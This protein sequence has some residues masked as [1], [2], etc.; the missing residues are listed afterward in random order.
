MSPVPTKTKRADTAACAT[1]KGNAGVLAVHSC[2]KGVESKDGWADQKSGNIDIMV[3]SG[4]GC[5]YQVGFASD[6]I[7]VIGSIGPSYGDYSCQLENGTPIWHSAKADKEVTNAVLYSMFIRNAGGAKLGI[8][9]FAIPPYGGPV[10]TPTFLWNVSTANVNGTGGEAKPDPI[11]VN[12]PYNSYTYSGDQTLS[13]S[14]PAAASTMTSLTV[15]AQSSAKNS[16]GTGT[17]GTVS[18][19]STSLGNSTSTPNATSAVST[20]LS[21]I[22]TTPSSTGT[23]SSSSSTITGVSKDLSLPFQITSTQLWIGGG[24]LLLIIVIAVGAMAFCCASKG[25]NQNVNMHSLGKPGR[26]RRG[27]HGPRPRQIEKQGYRYST[28]LSESSDMSTNSEEDDDTEVD[29]RPLKADFNTNI[30]LLFL[31]SAVEQLSSEEAGVRR[32]GMWIL[33]LVRSP[34][35]SSASSQCGAGGI[36]AIHNCPTGIIE[37]SQED[38]T[39]SKVGDGSV[40]A[41]ITSGAECMFRATFYSN[42]I[43][44]IGM[45]GPEYGDY[46]CHFEDQPPTW[47]SAKAEVQASNAVL[48]Q[49]EGMNCTS[50]FVSLSPGSGFLQHLGQA[51]LTVSLP[52][53]HAIAIR[54]LGG[55]KLGVTGFSVEMYDQ[56]IDRLWY[57]FN[58][59]TS[60]KP[61][62]GNKSN[63]NPAQM[64]LDPI[65]A[66]LPFDQYTYTGRQTETIPAPPEASTFTP[67]FATSAP[68]ATN[69]AQTTG[70]L[71]LSKN[72]SPMTWSITLP[73]STFTVSAA[74]SNTN[75]HTG[76]SDVSQ[77]NLSNKLAVTDPTNSSSTNSTSS[78]SS[79]SP[80]SEVTGVSKDLSLPFQ[81][82]STQMWIGGGVLLLLIAAVV[83]GM[84]CCGK[85]KEKN[86][87]NPAPAKMSS[88]G[89]GK[90]RRSAVA[91]FPKDVEK[92]AFQYTTG[93]D[94]DSSMMSTTDSEE[95]ARVPLKRSLS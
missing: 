60:D 69:A 27:T 7:M 89:K 74:S 87:D 70:L 45:V 46:S 6:A 35:L 25:G 39:A 64:K 78:S 56:P 82:T 84:I 63:G 47:H 26:T 95:E 55:S 12:L 59:S 76:S 19:N 68:T 61:F 75:T 44:V 73:G 2:P 86:Q 85:K 28:A 57:Y 65:P 94:T 54:N 33:A 36:I 20:G 92:D 24:V 72:T 31:F 51:A 41:M 48:C 79:S 90:A 13:I 29:R 43:K 91:P 23:T 66:M 14:A 53:S 42:A 10:I 9:G 4:S 88:L 5:Y 22:S 77:T 93:S 17:I 83:V 50:E 21:S 71:P 8:T 81:I 80:T 34:L 67:V 11:T 49:F 62:P 1:P 58:Q 37:G 16:T 18:R 32:G 52:G 15:D 30:A 3:A 38:W 40:N